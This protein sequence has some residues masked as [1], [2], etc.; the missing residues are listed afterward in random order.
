MNSYCSLN[1]NSKLFSQSSPSAA[2]QRYFCS[3]YS[4][5]IILSQTGFRRSWI[6]IQSTKFHSNNSRGK[7]FWTPC[8]YIRWTRLKI[9]VGWS[10]SQGGKRWLRLPNRRDFKNKA[11]WLQDGT[12][13]DG[14]WGRGAALTP[15]SCSDSGL[16]GRVWVTP[17]TSWIDI[18]KSRQTWIK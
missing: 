18:Q 16:C 13:R 3:F 12:G 6:S 5:S 11:R 1:Q 17:R 7:K 14:G 10:E 8:F 4:L 15:S 9:W 2:D